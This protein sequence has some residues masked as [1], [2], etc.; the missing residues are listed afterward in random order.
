MDQDLEAA[1]GFLR[2]RAR[3][4]LAP[5]T[6]C[7]NCGTPLRGAWCYV[8]GQSAED[9]HRSA[10][11]LVWE[12]LENFFHADGRL[13]RTI[14]RL[15]ADPG[16]LTHDYLAGRR[17]PQI[18]PMRLFLVMVLLVFLTGWLAGPAIQ[19]PQGQM[20]APGELDH[21][22]VHTFLGPDWDGRVS[23]WLRVHLGRAAANPHA[24]IAAT[25]EWGH[26]LAVLALPISAMMLA[27][28]FAFRR[29]YVLFDHLIFSM[30]SLSFVGLLVA[31]MLLGHAAGL[32]GL[33]PVL[34]LVP[35]HLFFHMRGVYGTGVIGTVF[36]MG[37]LA[38]LS[39][40]SFTLLLLL[41]A[42]VG[43]GSLE[44]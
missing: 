28:I 8:C 5:G 17:A 23:V 1:G 21:W 29:G 22:R 16:R 13:W 3:H 36:R 6:P 37:V 19:L 40:V 18:P 42:A 24:L 4:A 33:A 31:L 12:G 15:I 11:A 10:V 26:R 32:S 14:P 7:A 43:L 2:W 38:T 41:V 25:A 20:L 35:V 39:V 9:F 30:H 34:L 44:G 27:L